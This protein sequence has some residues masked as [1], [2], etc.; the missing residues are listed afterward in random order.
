M[1]TPTSKV[2]YEKLLWQHEKIFDEV[3]E[4]GVAGVYEFAK[5]FLQQL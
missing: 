5:Q 3:L 2:K 1:V 4:K